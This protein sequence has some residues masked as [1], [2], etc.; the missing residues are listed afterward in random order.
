MS[1]FIKKVCHI[2]TIHPRYDVRIFYKECMS[3]SRYFHVTLIVADGKGNE[4]FGNVEILD[5]GKN[6]YGKLL[7]RFLN[8]FRIYKK[9]ASLN[10]DIYHFHD[11]D[12]LLFGYLL[13]RQGFQVIYD[14]H[15]DL[16]RQILGKEY[17]SPLIRNQISWLSGVLENYLTRKFRAIVCATPVIAKR[18]RE[19]NSV[20][21]IL[22][23]F[24]LKNEFHEN[25][26]YENRKNKI[27]YI[28]GISDVRGIREFLNASEKLKNEFDIELAGSIENDT[29]RSFIDSFRSKR[30]IVYHGIIG[31]DGIITLLSESKIGI[32]VLHPVPN[33]LTSLPVK[34]FEYMAAGL[35]VIASDFPLWKEIIENAG[36]GICV[37]PLDVDQ[38]ADAIR[39]LLE[40]PEKAT[41]MGKNGH[42][43]IKNRYNWEFEES[44]LINLYNSI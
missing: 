6:D 38:I 3:L 30:R 25:I 4:T 36:C 7:S 13:R 15:E 41:A 24:P 35:P 34:M 31:R 2:T 20:V 28:G 11:P 43:A 16:P 33:H 29:L 26:S 21:T 32:V 12:F 22:S 40:N 42:E 44:N 8:A 19:L 18:F 37:N 39:L 27:C 14:A 1:E 9:A 23:N 5:T 17:I 10:Q